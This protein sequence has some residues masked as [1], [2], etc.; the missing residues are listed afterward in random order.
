ML[1][2]RSGVAAESWWR[3]A[4]HGHVQKGSSSL[5]RVLLFLLV[6][7]AVPAP[8]SAKH[9]ER[10]TKSGAWVVPTGF[11]AYHLDKGLA[12]GVA[13]LLGRGTR[14]VT[15]LDMGAGKG[16]YVRMLQTLGLPNVTG[17]EGVHNIKD[18][19]SGRVQQREFTVAFEPC[20]GYDVVMCLEV[21]E[22]I[23]RKL[24]P[25]FLSN[26][27][28][29]ARHGIIISWAK[30]HQVGTGHVNL[31]SRVDVLKLMDELGF[32]PDNEASKRASEH[33]TL[34][35]FKTNILALH[36]RGEPSPFTI[37]PGSLI[38]LEPRTV[39]VEAAPAAAAANPHQRPSQHWTTVTRLRMPLISCEVVMPTSRR[40]STSSS[41]SAMPPV[42]P[43]ASLGTCCYC[44]HSASSE[45]ACRPSGA[46][47]ASWKAPW[48]LH[49]RP[50]ALAHGSSSRPLA[51]G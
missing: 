21:A 32:V 51:T 49:E 5:L 35:W 10:P 6:L 47:R 9:N 50:L 8:A 48:S 26:L 3:D 43:T 14:N 1:R 18:L 4:E 29:S 24:E 45:K 36:R 33:A 39:R 11:R 28:C 30:M 17:Y 31:R 27:N 38:A 40:G 42:R 23:P 25:I 7:M 46:S 41:C 19:T 13:T 16:L 2:V 37:S 15:L 44:R 20:V 22:H 12:N 34:P